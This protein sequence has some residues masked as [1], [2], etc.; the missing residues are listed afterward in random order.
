MGRLCFSTLNSLPSFTSCPT[1]CLMPLSAAQGCAACCSSF[2]QLAVVMAEL[3]Q[4]QLRFLAHICPW[5]SSEQIPA[6]PIPYIHTAEGRAAVGFPTPQLILRLC[7]HENPN[8]SLWTVLMLLNAPALP[9][10]RPE[11]ILSPLGVSFYLLCTQGSTAESQPWH[12]F[13]NHTQLGILG[14][15]IKSFISSKNR[16]LNIFQG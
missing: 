11:L 7:F 14:S 13:L 4:R 8:S 12:N 9:L 10:Q 1:E 5:G 16:F 15:L 6:P 2:L 3:R